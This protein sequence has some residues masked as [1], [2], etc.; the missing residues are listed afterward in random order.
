MSFSINDYSLA[1]DLTEE[2]TQE[3]SDKSVSERKNGVVALDVSESP[4]E[5]LLAARQKL[6]EAEQLAAQIVEAARLESA[7]IKSTAQAK[8]NAVPLTLDDVKSQWIS[9]EIRDRPLQATLLRM[10]PNGWRVMIE[11]EASVLRDQRIDFISQ[12][13]RDEAISDLTRSLGLEYQYFYQLTDNQG[14]PSPLLV[15]TER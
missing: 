9:V 2:V 1:R 6:E 15:V 12:K 13:K 3:V 7:K 5:I 4:E 14:N 11:M 8:V 10:L